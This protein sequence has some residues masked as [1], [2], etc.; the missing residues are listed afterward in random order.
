[1]KT[2]TLI[3]A[4]SLVLIIASMY[5]IVENPDTN[6]NAMIAGGIALVGLVFN[7]VSFMTKS[8]AR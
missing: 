4:A 8:K 6:R 1:M 2:N 3:Y 7:V 5:M